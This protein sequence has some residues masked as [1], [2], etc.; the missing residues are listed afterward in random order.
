MKY[1]IHVSYDLGCH[2]DPEK[3]SDDLMELQT[4]GAR[5]DG[6]MLRWYIENDA[7]KIVDVGKIHKNTLASMA[8][9]SAGGQ[10]NVSL[11]TNDPIFQRLD[12]QR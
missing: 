3:G 1:T 12:S 5:L 4:E 2:Y 9:M 10:K 7:G 8:R 6:E 11:V